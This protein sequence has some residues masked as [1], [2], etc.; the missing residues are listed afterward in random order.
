MSASSPIKRLNAEL[1][2]QLGLVEKAAE[3]QKPVQQIVHLGMGA[4]HR[5]H[6]AVYTEQANAVTGDNWQIIGVS[7]R[8]CNVRDQLVPQAGFYSVTET[9]VT[10]NTQ[11]VISVIKDVLVAAE[12]PAAVLAVI[13]QENTE[14][15][16]LTITEKGYCHDPASGN[17]D[18]QNPDIQY[19]LAHLSAPRTAIGFLV[20]SLQERYEQG[21]VPFTVLC[22]D[23]LP[24][25]GK[26]LGEIVKQFAQQVD[27]QLAAWISE[28]VPFPNTMVD[29]IVPATTPEDIAELGKKTGYQDLAM[30]KTERFS[31]WVIEDKFALGKPDWQKVGVSLVADVEPFE[32]AKLRLLNGAHS[33]LAYLGYLSGYDYVHQVMQNKDLAA[34][35]KYMMQQEIIPTIE[36]PE[37]MDLVAYSDELLQRFSNPALNHR[38][39]QIAMDGSQKMPQRLLGTIEDKLAAQSPFDSLCFAVAGWLR[40]T[41]AFDQKG[42]PID[43]QDPLA[44]ELLNIQQRD[45][46]DIDNLIDGYL[47]FDKVFSATLKN[48]DV[49]RHKLTYWLGI[50]LA[51]G[52]QTAVKVLLLEI[53]AHPQAQQTSQ[54]T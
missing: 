17:L 5:A 31:Q 22:C 18:T 48:S 26:T 41:M 44:A 11:Q 7:F 40:Y 2:E 14:I 35:L 50:I 19:D 25:N 30:V 16:S 36:P 20:G 32:N 29:R 51:N 54:P 6:Q 21:F 33:A 42:D 37:G 3:Q 52:V 1:V 45:F 12:N 15:V 13:G 23:N 28:N 27:P 46:Y 53:Q 24:S 49:F 43:V 34:F 38:T 8:S 39:Y 10:G 9:D 4:F 47:S